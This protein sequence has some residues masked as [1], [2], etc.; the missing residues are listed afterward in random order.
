M[1]TQSGF[2]SF[3]V[4]CCCLLLVESSF[5]PIYSGQ[6]R[7]NLAG[8]A[9]FPNQH[10]KEWLKIQQNP[11]FAAK[12]K[13]IHTVNTYFILKY[14]SWLK[15][16]L[17]DFGFLFNTND[18]NAWNDYAY[19]RGIFHVNITGWKCLDGLLKSYAYHPEFYRVEVEGDKAT[20]EMLPDAQIVSQDIPDRNDPG[21][22]VK[23]TFELVLLGKS[24]LIQKI[25]CRDPVYYALPRNTDFDREAEELAKEYK[26]H[27]S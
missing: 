5:A 21:P 19:E 25:L 7:A 13:I 10:Y 26:K 16:T 20:V 1:Q 3:L 8:A 6:E 27:R 12:D 15:G 4:L 17:L 9:V 22:W 2:K 18:V 14:E 11:D 24:W 23:H